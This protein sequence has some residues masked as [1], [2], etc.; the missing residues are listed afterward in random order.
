[1]D[2]WNIDDQED[3][4][5]RKSRTLDEMMDSLASCGSDSFLATN[6]LGTDTDQGIQ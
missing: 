6:F 5:A 4:L 3:L 1:M 2:D